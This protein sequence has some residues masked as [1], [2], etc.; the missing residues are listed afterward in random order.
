MQAFNDEDPQGR[1]TLGNFGFL[2]L[3]LEK[4]AFL[5]FFKSFESSHACVQH[6]ENCYTF[7]IIFA[8]PQGREYGCSTEGKLFLSI[9]HLYEHFLI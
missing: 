4:V 8:P 6:D 9:P 2:A 7:R 1:R 5:R 3:P